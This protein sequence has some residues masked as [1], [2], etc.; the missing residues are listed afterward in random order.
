MEAIARV[1]REREVTT[2]VV[3]H[4]V[5]LAIWLSGSVVAM[6]EGRVA[7]SG[8]S[9]GLLEPGLLDE[10]FGVRFLRYS[11]ER[12]KHPIVAPERRS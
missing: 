6:S 3:T 11:S 2:L 5:N 4:D 1:N 8:Q 10:I 9:S 7:W 12:G